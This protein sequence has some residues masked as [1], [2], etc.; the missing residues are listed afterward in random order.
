MQGGAIERAGLNIHPVDSDELVLFTVRDPKGKRVGSLDVHQLDAGR[1]E[2]QGIELGDAFQK[3]G[4]GSDLYGR[5]NAWLAENKG[6]KLVSDLN[7]TDAAEAAWQSMERKGLARRLPDEGEFRLPAR[8]LAENRNATPRGFRYEMLPPKTPAPVISR[9]DELLA[10]HN[11]AAAE[12]LSTSRRFTAAKKELEDWL[13]PAVSGGGGAY[14]SRGKVAVAHPATPGAILEDMLAASV[15]GGGGAPGAVPEWMARAAAK[16]P[17]WMRRAGAAQQASRRAASGEVPEWLA[18]ASPAVRERMLRTPAGRAA[19]ERPVEQA[20]AAALR[21]EG[22]LADDV[23]QAAKVVGDYEAAAADLADVLGPGA[24]PGAQRL[25]QGYRA[26][27]REQSDKMAGQSVQASERLA[28]R[29]PVPMAQAAV[30]PTGRAMGNAADAIGALDV[31]H[32]L[33]VPIKHIPVVGPLLGLLLKARAVAR[34]YRRFGGTVPRS[35]ETTIAARSAAARNRLAAAMGRALDVAAKGAKAARL[36]ATSTAAILGARLFAGPEERRQGREGDD[37][38]KLYERRL[39]ELIAAQDPA[40]LQQSLRDR[41]PVGDPA[42]AQSLEAVMQRKAAF[43]L[44]KAPRQPTLPD[45][46]GGGRQW[47]PS[48]FDL[49]TFARYVE[50][51]ND[52]VAVIER[53]ADYGDVTIEAAETV[54]AVYPKLFAA[55]QQHLLEQ[56]PLLQH[57][58]SYQ[59][60]IRLSILFDVPLDGSLSPSFIGAMQQQYADADERQAQPA[61]EGGGIMGQ[62]HQ[63]G[64]TITIST[65][66]QTPLDRRGDR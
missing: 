13:A 53:L 50:A 21:G 28:A 43:L 6:A 19:M 58:L 47:Q 56:A 24:P 62:P 18:G 48:R 37:V 42:L 8:G 29:S 23:A 31:L 51:A 38:Q 46:A 45:L 52:P 34:V 26:A 9:A 3:R 35:L 17:A 57:E 20:V 16:Q 33:G 61:A 4:I 63:G 64:Q 40:V 32:D 25:S 11:P 15:K 39:D 60:R 44:E 36:P 55:A 27:L 12:I 30:T 14:A 22:E 65:R 66:Y 5:A 41:L 59:R 1:Y 49:A 2:V 10:Q 54:K 7:R